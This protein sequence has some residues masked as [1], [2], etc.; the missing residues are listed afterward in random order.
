MTSRQSLVLWLIQKFNYNSYLEIGCDHDAT[1]SCVNLL[2]KI[3][4]DPARGGNVRMT[5]DDFFAQCNRKFDLIFVDGLH[6]AYQVMKDVQNSLLH[7]NENGTILMHDCNPI[8]EINQI[9]PRITKNW[10]GDCWKTY[11]ILRGRDDI[12]IACSDFDH[13]IGV[14]RA[15]P[16]GSVLNVSNATIADLTWNDFDTNRLEWLRLMKS[17]E[18]LDWI[19]S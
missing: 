2:D 14:I 1:F 15:R 9:V 5:S 7:L 3:G 8:H 6:H 13:G 11:V 12:D 4:V 18:L 17:A 10:N 19:T 16:N